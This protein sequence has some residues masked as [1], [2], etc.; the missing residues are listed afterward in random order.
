[1]SIRA[2]DSKTE[3]HKRAFHLVF[4]NRAK[5]SKG[6]WASASFKYSPYKKIG[7]G[8]VLRFSVKGDASGALLNVQLETPREWGY[9]VSEHYVKLDFL[10]WRDFEMPMCER[11]AS[12]MVKYKWPYDWNYA[13]VFHRLINPNYVSALNFFINEVPPEG[14]TCVEVSDVVLVPDR[15][16]EIRKV[17][18]S[19]NSKK[20]VLPFEMKSGQF[21]ELEDDFWTL[22]TE[23]GDPLLRR[24]KEHAP[25]LEKGLNEIEYKGE[26][27]DGRW[28]RAK[29]EVFSIGEAKTAVRPITSLSD[30]EKKMMVYEALDPQIYAPQKGLDSL[31]DITVRPGE[32]AGIEVTVFGLSPEFTL[33]VGDVVKKIPEIAKG[34]YRKFILEGLFSGVCPVSV[35]TQK[36]DE[37]PF[38]RLEF[39]KRYK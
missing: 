28:A 1:M 23:N 39:V 27:V 35:E 12:E 33:R 4:G 29:V 34:D 3:T 38:I 25:C 15:I 21:A 36:A 13:P 17:E 7:R 22:Y 10:G 37:N 8:A 20:I 11:D 31:E 30:D 24:R 32:K 19:V 9:A 18:V 5:V 14:K 6:A 2:K 16:D 26:C